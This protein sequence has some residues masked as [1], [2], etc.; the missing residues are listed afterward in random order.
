MKKWA[1]LVVGLYFLILIVLTWPVGWVAFYK[2]HDVKITDMFFSKYYW[3]FIGAMVLGQAALLMVPVQLASRRPVIRR[4]IIPSLAASGLMMGLLIVGVLFSVYEFTEKGVSVESRLLI[5]FFS[6]GGAIW[7]L[8]AVLFHWL[9]RDRDPGDL[10]A[11]KC[12]ILLKGSIL[13]LL[14]AVPTHIVARHRDYCCA[15]FET[16][17]GLAM[18]LSAMLFSFGPG[19]FFLFADRWKKLHPETQVREP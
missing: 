2:E 8:W 1:L 15:G 13:E 5:R 12:R 3:A 7:F 11:Q 16:F 10:I 9:S 14:I 6:V 4:S 18:G 17:F 19:V